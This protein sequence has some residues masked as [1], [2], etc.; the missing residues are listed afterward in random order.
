MTTTTPICHHGTHFGGDVCVSNTPPTFE[1]PAVLDRNGNC[2]TAIHP[3]CSTGKFKNG[4]CVTAH[5]PNCDNGSHLVNDKC[6][7]L[8]RP[9]CEAGFILRN[10]RCKRTSE[11]QDCKAGYVFKNGELGTVA[12]RKNTQPAPLGHAWKEMIACLTLLPNAPKGLHL[13]NNRCIS[14]RPPSCP[15]GTRFERSTRECVS[16]E[17]P[18]CGE[19]QVYKDGSCVLGSGKCVEYQF[20]P[21]GAPISGDF[22]S[23]VTGNGGYIN[24]HQ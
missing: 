9:D 6:E 1:A 13:H 21:T 23:D 8:T 7:S 18:K 12:C 4:K 17:N 24:L 14:T 22:D 2:I 20:C 15:D 16:V 3:R 19:G 5:I 11:R 10:G